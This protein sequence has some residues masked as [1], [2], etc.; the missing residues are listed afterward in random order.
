MRN[1]TLLSSTLDSIPEGKR[2]AS[3]VAFD[4]DS[5][6]TYV[7]AEKTLPDGGTD[8]EIWQLPAGDDVSDLGT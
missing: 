5:N 1:L 8:V 2:V 4:T 7:A 3:G 6:L